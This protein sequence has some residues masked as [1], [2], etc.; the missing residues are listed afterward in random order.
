METHT[1]SVP[2]ARVYYETR[3]RGPLLLMIICGPAD[4]DVFGG[5]AQ[6]LEDRY[7]VVT[8]DT[9]GH[10]RSPVEDEAVEQPVAVEAED[11]SRLLAALGM[12]EVGRK[13][14]G[15]RSRQETIIPWVRSSPAGWLLAA[16][17]RTPRGS[18][19]LGTDPV[20]HEPRLGAVPPAALLDARSRVSRLGR[21]ALLPSAPQ[22]RPLSI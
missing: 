6:A 9:R 1:L 12:P 16:A 17:C 5:L 4:A 10:S 21:H 15:S 22:A 20:E 14:R 8:F 11:A 7:M 2:G 3:G 19:L 18:T 13:Q